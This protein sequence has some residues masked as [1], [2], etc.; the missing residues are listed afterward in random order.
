[1]IRLVV[2]RIVLSVITLFLVAGIMYVA[3]DVLPGDAC[4]AYLGRSA[5]GEK[6]AQ[7]QSEHGLDR[8]LPV[9]FGDW[10]TKAATGDFGMSIAR[11]KPVTDIVMQRFRNSAVL[12]VLAGLIAMPLAI[13]LG[14]LAAL[15]R[16][17][18]FDIAISTVALAIMTVP[19]FVSA[20]TIILV[21]SIWLKVLPG[22]NVVPPDAPLL[23]L[24]GSIISPAIVLAFISI[25]HVLRIVRA[26]VIEVLDSPY[27]DM[28]RLR[29][30]PGWRIMMVHVL[31]N[32]LMPA[33]NVIALQM[34]WLLGGVVVVEVIFNY[35]G[36]GRLTVDS[37]S[38]RDLPLVLGIAMLSALLYILFNLLADL[39]S[40][41]VNPRLR[42]AQP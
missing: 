3:V 25:A 24:M 31:P 35:P 12:A 5:A 38:D 19:E 18:L 15:R 26:S 2:R 7:C 22:I 4:T 11:N 17:R 20:T 27:V 9:R 10:L 28:A 13:L 33:V 36:L 1:M 37:I 39:F 42:R 23:T 30:L 41:F 29:G 21:F 6:L 14:V 16:D 8:S 32:A 40:L 34:A